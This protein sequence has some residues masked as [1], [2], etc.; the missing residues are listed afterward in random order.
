VSGNISPANGSAFKKCEKKNVPA[1]SA[2]AFRTT[3]MVRAITMKLAT[4]TFLAASLGWAQS[5]WLGRDN[6]QP[7]TAHDRETLTLRGFYL[8]SSTVR[9]SVTLVC[10]DGRLLS[11]AFNTFLAARGGTQTNSLEKTGKLAV[12]IRVGEK[13]QEHKEWKLESGYTSFHPGS[14]FVRKLVSA[15]RVDIGFS[16]SPTREMTA[17]FEPSPADAPRIRKACGIR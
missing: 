12:A 17:E 8:S 7:N 2:G 5:S 16:L 13:K 1:C 11:S 3:I 14:R 15:D 10:Q 4:F 6:E 9:P